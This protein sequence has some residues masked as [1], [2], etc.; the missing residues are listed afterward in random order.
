VPNT[1]TPNYNLAK[2][3]Q[4]DVLWDDEINGNFDIIDQALHQVTIFLESHTT[5][6][7]NPH[8]TTYDQVGAAPASHTHQGSDIIGQVA[9][10]ANADRTDN[11]HLKTENNLLYFSTDNINWIVAGEMTKA[12]YDTNNDGIVDNADRVD[13]IHFRIQNNLLQFSTDNTT[14]IVA[15]DMT[16]AVYDTNNDGIVDNADRVDGYDAAIASNP[17]TVAVRNGNG[18]LSAR[19]FGSTAPPGTPPI[20]VAST[21]VCT[22]LNAD[23]VDGYHAN[24][25][26]LLNNPSSITINVPHGNTINF[27]TGGTTRAY[28]ND[29]GLV[30]AVYNSDIAEGFVTSETQ[31]PEEGDI[32]VFDRDG[33]VKK[34]QKTGRFVG[35]V[36]Y[37]PGLLL[38]M[39]HNWQEEFE[40]NKKVPVALLGQV[41][42]NVYGGWMGVKPGDPLT[43]GKNNTLRKK[44]FFWEPTVSIALESVPKRTK[45]KIRVLLR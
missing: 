39:T 23:M 31:Q 37:R 25:L 29:Y 40:K 26:V 27:S 24:S 1:Y 3:S 19:V 12:V 20:T 13:D 21:T 14:W 42:T 30:G 41:Q 35:V 9:Y 36:S 44:L 38:G 45:R 6:T 28:V 11:I 10:A 34:F 22:N 18:D 33:R 43:L 7:D 15:G 5:N 8:N 2:P 16:K 4:G 17:N 32:M